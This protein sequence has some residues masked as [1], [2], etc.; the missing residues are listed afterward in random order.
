M[1]FVLIIHSLVCVLLVICILMQAGRGGGLTEGFAAAENMFGA[2]TNEFMVRATA[3]LAVIFLVTSLTLA[4]LSARRDQSLMERLMDKTKQPDIKINIP[5]DDKKTEAL[6][7]KAAVE[8][9]A[10]LTP[11][12]TET[13]AAGTPAVETAPAAAQTK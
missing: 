8:T 5:L 2:R 9:T 10:P 13:P 4:N 3:V 1:T 11:V 6:D 12:T 7:Q